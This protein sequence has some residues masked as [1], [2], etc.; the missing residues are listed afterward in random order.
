M[1]YRWVIYYVVYSRCNSCTVDMIT[2]ITNLEALKMGDVS[3]NFSRSEFACKCGCGFEVV[4][5]Q[6]LKLL[7]IIRKRYNSPIKI[8]SACRCEPHNES[9]GGAKGSKHKLGIA[10]DI[11]VKGVTPSEVFRFVDKF[12]PNSYGVKAYKPFTHVDVRKTKWRG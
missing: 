7:E 4:D 6:L 10:A 8:N 12:M 3:V 1:V 9:V 2:I 5:V 11:V